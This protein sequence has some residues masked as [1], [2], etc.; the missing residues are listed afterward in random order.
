MRGNHYPPVQDEH[1]PKETVHSGFSSNYTS[2]YDHSEN[3]QKDVEE[4][5]NNES[6]TSIDLK[7]LGPLG[8]DSNGSLLQDSLDVIAFEEAQPFASRPG[9]ADDGISPMA[10]IKEDVELSIRQ[11][12]RDADTPW[13]LSPEPVPERMPS[14]RS[15][16]H[17]VLVGDQ[18]T[19][20]RTL[21]VPMVKLQEKLIAINTR[22]T[23]GLSVSHTEW[24]ELRSMT[25]KLG[26]K[27]S[28]EVTFEW[29]QTTPQP[30][31]S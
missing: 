25:A 31:V 18:H 29:E 2:G 30:S 13:K 12:R 7:N 1:V 21:V 17:R 24:E 19:P 15:T 26:N 10:A 3:E 20:S 5:F 16:S 28:N 4:A 22:V 9:Q 23:T 27:F 6:N 11:Q 14:K 8:H